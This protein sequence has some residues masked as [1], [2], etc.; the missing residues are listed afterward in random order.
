[1]SEAE[2]IWSLGTI[3]ALKTDVCL[4]VSLMAAH[5]LFPCP[6]RV[7]FFQLFLED[8]CENTDS[9]NRGT[10]AAAS[11]HLQPLMEIQSEEEEEEEEEG[12]G[13]VCATADLSLR[14]QQAH[15][16]PD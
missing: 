8:S 5:K 4:L 9:D 3:P 12:G 11:W 10:E 14:A 7:T 13:G 15:P 2:G 6:S 1:M 16:G